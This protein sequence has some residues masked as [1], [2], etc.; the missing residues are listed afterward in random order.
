MKAAKLTLLFCVIALALALIGWAQAKKVPIPSGATISAPGRFQIIV[1]PSVRADLFLLDTETGRIWQR[2]QISY[3]KGQPDA[4][5]L[6]K[7]FDTEDDYLQWARY[8]PP[9]KTPAEECAVN[10]KSL[11]ACIEGSLNSPDIQAECRKLYQ[12][13]LESCPK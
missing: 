11:Q 13:L 4:W 3:I 10:K 2:T 5:L 8:Q 1:N 9:L 7:K 12:P 6:Q